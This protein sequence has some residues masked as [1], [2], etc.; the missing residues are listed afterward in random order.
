MTPFH[1]NMSQNKLT[2]KTLLL[3]KWTRWCCLFIFLTRKCYARHKKVSCQ[4]MMTTSTWAY[5]CIGSRK[6]T[7]FSAGNLGLHLWSR[8]HSESN[9]RAWK[10]MKATCNLTVPWVL[11]DLAAIQIAGIKILL[12]ESCT[13]QH[14]CSLYYVQRHCTGPAGY[15]KKKKKRQK[16]EDDCKSVN[17]DQNIC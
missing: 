8:G 12:S 9:G 17:C 2:Q 4:A 7:F 16:L 5:N 13:F 3:R 14:F 15:Q 10:N 6:L 11:I 1:K